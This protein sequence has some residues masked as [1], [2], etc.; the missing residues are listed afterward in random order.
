MSAAMPMLS[1]LDL[2]SIKIPADHSHFLVPLRAWRQGLEM[3][4]VTRKSAHGQ[5]CFRGAPGKIDRRL[6]W[7]HAAASQAGIDIDENL[8]ACSVLSLRT[9]QFADICRAIHAHQEGSVTRKL[10]E[11]VG[12]PFAGNFVGDKY[13][14]H[15]VL[16]QNLGLP[17]GRA[18]HADGAHP[19][20]LPGQQRRFVVFKVRPELG[21]LIREKIGHC[22]EIGLHRVEIDKL[23]PA[24]ESAASPWLPPRGCSEDRGLG[25]A[26]FTGGPHG[27]A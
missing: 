24:S 17:N 5:P 15:A 8:E 26:A 21:R 10:G 3:A 1:R 19:E 14:V 12:L 13:V 16:D 7:R 9:G 25:P 20:L 11:A 2:V 4:L 23:T 22:T 6:A 27:I 18:G